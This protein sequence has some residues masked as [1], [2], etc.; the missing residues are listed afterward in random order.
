MDN[1]K[2]EARNYRHIED[3]MRDRPP[4]GRGVVHVSDRHGIQHV[5]NVYHF[6]CRKGLM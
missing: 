6:E 1:T 3:E 5:F 2:L 4:G